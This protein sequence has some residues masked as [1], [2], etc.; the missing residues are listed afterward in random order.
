MDQI[1]K[2]IHLY[3]LELIQSGH[4]YIYHV[5]NGNSNIKNCENSICQLY[6]A[7]AKSNRMD[8]GK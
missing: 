6:G 4:D 1:T 8:L 2:L 5:L 7:Y 3:P